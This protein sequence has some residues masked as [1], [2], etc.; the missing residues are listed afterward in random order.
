MDPLDIKDTLYILENILRDDNKPQTD[1]RWSPNNVA[2]HNLYDAW[3][4]RDISKMVE[5]INKDPSIID[6]VNWRGETVL[7][8][9]AY[10]G[11]IEVVKI[12]IE[13]GANINAKNMVN[14]TPLHF[15][16]LNHHFDIIEFLIKSNA[17]I[18]AKPDSGWSIWRCLVDDPR[19]V[20]STE[21]NTLLSRKKA[22]K[23]EI[24]KNNL[25]IR[26]KEIN[27]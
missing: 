17:D 16:A 6:I 25:Q 13:K 9:A 18:S 4:E 27:D 1:K 23:E 10:H 24:I 12:L 14:V 5:L 19:F 7:H 26:E 15:A 11:N 21:E 20:M 22:I 3:K 8:Q 2:A